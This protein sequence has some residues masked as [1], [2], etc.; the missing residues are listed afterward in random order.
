MDL[1]GTDVEDLYVD[2]G[3]NTLWDIALDAV[4]GKVYIAAHGDIIRT[5]LDGSGIE[6]LVDGPGGTMFGI[7]SIVFVP[8]PSVFALILVA[9]PF[10]SAHKRRA[11]KRQRC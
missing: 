5:N 1:D 4:S 11:R 10:L 9:V 3:G 2:T 7:G 6:T 8:E